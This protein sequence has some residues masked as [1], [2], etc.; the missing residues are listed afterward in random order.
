MMKLSK[1]G[2]DFIVRE[3]GERLTAYRDSVG[4]WTIGVGHTGEVD[5]EP[6]GRGMAISAVKSREVFRLDISRF[7]NAVNDLVR[8]QLNQNQF[9]ALV[10]LVFN[11]GTGAFAHSTLLKRLN[12]GDYSGAA[13]AFLMWR[14]AGGKPILLNRRKREKALFE[15]VG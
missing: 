4:I 10:S 8:V 14:N 6:V 11:I 1:Y 15:K 9:D 2:E 7:E 3:E 12:A 5:G 13:E